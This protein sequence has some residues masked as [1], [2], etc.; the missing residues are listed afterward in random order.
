MPAGGWAWSAENCHDSPVLV[1]TVPDMVD[2]ETVPVSAAVS[3][4]VSETCSPV[5]EPC[6]QVSMLSPSHRYAAARSPLTATATVASR[7]SVRPEYT[8][9]REAGSAVGDGAASDDGAGAA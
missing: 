4:P 7:P 1:V 9:C 5:A 6:S 3:R 8:A 2:P